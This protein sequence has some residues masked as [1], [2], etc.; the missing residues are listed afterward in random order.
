[1]RFRRTRGELGGERGR[2][3]NEAGIGDDAVHNTVILHHF[4]RDL[5]GGLRPMP[6]QLRRYLVLRRIV[7]NKNS[8]FTIDRTGERMHIGNFQSEL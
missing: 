2:F 4:G 1:M 6:W 8:W 5:F 7:E 3:L